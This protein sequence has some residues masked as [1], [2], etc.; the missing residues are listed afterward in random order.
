MHGGLTA[1]FEK[2]SLDAELLQMMQAYFDPIVVDEAALALDAIAE[3]GVGVNR[4][5]NI[6]N[7]EGNKNGGLP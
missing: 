1:S 7:I 2:L 6:A 5:W 4:R 3:A